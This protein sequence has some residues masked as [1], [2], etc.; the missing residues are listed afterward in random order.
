MPGYIGARSVK[1][2][3]AVTVINAPTDNYLQASAF[4]ILP[5]DTEPRHH[6]PGRRHPPVDA[7]FELRRP[8]P[9]RSRPPTSWTAHT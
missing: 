1:W 9:P 8:H 5:P 7:C 6:R 2:V 4:R 3:T